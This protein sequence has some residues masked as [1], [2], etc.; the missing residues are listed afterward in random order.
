MRCRLGVTASRQQCVNAKGGT[1]GYTASLTAEG[2]AGPMRARVHAFSTL[3]DPFR[4]IFMCGGLKGGKGKALFLRRNF[5]VVQANDLPLAVNLLPHVGLE[6]SH[7]A[8]FT[9]GRAS[10]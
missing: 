3:Q 5:T 8:N 9:L 10:P 7:G 1:R 4:T 2:A 6:R